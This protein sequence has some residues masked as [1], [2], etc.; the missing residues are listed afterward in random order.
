VAL[1][2]SIV[3]NQIRSSL[4]VKPISGKPCGCT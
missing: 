4:F 2:N 3:A 1:F